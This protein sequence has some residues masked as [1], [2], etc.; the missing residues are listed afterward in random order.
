MLQSSRARPPRLL[1]VCLFYILYIF[2]YF[3]F[4]YFYLLCCFVSYCFRYA[5]EQ[6]CEWDDDTIK[7]AAK[8][9]HLNCLKYVH[10]FFS[11]PLSVSL[12][13]LL[14]SLILFLFVYYLLTSYHRWAKENGCE[15]H[16]SAGKG[17]AKKGHIDC[18]K[19]TFYFFY[20]LFKFFIIYC[21]I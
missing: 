21:F 16:M 14:Y 13:F 1:E 20:S 18:L 11:F 10:Y 3:Y 8:R 6:G 12:P 9:G 4:T 15:W 17:A 19:Y 5:H 7:I 2:I